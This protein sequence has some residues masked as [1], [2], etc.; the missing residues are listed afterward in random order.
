MEKEGHIRRMKN[1]N[2]YSV[3]TADPKVTM[4]LRGDILLEWPVGSKKGM[5]VSKI[6]QIQEKEKHAKNHQI[7]DGVA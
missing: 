4:L 6:F 2:M 1:K 5:A 3:Q 7:P